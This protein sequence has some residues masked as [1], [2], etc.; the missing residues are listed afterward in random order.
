MAAGSHFEAFEQDGET[1][2]QFP[3]TTNGNWRGR[4]YSRK[5]EGR[6]LESRP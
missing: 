4:C 6:T 3:L 5:G 1:V 2:V